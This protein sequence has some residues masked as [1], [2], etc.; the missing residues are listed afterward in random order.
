MSSGDSNDAGSLATRVQVHPFLD[1]QDHALLHG[2]ARANGEP[3]SSLIRR[4][5]KG[6]LRSRASGRSGARSATG[7]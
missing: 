3:L 5:L 4:V 6:Y 1:A 7:E 2:I